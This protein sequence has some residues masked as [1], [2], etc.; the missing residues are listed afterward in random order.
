MQPQ[1]PWTELAYATCTISIV[2]C[3]WLIW[4]VSHFP[5]PGYSIKIIRLISILDLLQC[6]FVIVTASIDNY[7]YINLALFCLASSMTLNT[8]SLLYSSALA[9]LSYK[10]IKLMRDFD[11]A[12]YYKQCYMI[13]IPVSAISGFTYFMTLYSSTMSEDIQDI[14]QFFVVIPP[15]IIA[16]LVSFVS[17]F[18]QMQLAKSVFGKDFLKQ[19]NIKIEK[20]IAYPVAQAVMYSPQILM[21]MLYSYVSTQTFNIISICFNLNGLVNSLLYLYVRNIREESLAVSKS[22]SMHEMANV[23]K[24]IE[25]KARS[26]SDW[27]GDIL[28]KALKES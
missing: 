23:D 14:L 5:N 28:Q 25:N 8:C 24:D 13:I 16:L 1:G 12:G 9:L 20:V 7:E 4:N 3:L 22:I 10:S 21:E 15:L 18:K 27:H 6:I 19:M 17:Y 26:D 11:E 2:S